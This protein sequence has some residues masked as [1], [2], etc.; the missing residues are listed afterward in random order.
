MTDEAIAGQLRAEQLAGVLRHTRGIMIANICNA[1]I[2]LAAQ[3][4]APDQGLAL[5]WAAMVV[6]LVALLHVRQRTR[7][8]R[9]KPRTVSERAIRRASLY[10]LAL[11]GLWAAVPLLFFNSA[12]HGVQLVIA[13]LCAGM[14]A[15]GAFG[16]G[17][18]PIAA[19]A[20][21]APIFIASAI[22][23]GRSGDAT[24]LLVA[25]LLVVYAL[26]LLRTVFVY[27][28]ENAVRLVAQFDAEQ[29]IRRDPLTQL[30]NRVGFTESVETAFARLASTGE[31]FTLLWLDLDS[32][33]AINDRL[34]HTVGDEI[35]I[36]AADRL[37]ACAG[38]RDA[39]ARLGGD[40]FAVIAAGIGGLDA[41][42]AVARRVVEAF[43]KPFH[44][45]GQEV[46][47]TASIGV[48]IAPGDGS[49]PP[50]LLRSADIALYHAKS[51]RGGSFRF[52][53]VSDHALARERRALQHDLGNALHRGEFRLVYQPILALSDN[54]IVGFEALLRWQ[55]PTRGSV[56][57]T[58]F[59]PVA[60]S[61]GLIRSIGEWVIEE[62]CRT[63]AAWP[64][65]SRISVN[66]SA[67]QFR[68]PAIA[69]QIMAAIAASGLA[70]ERFEIE[71]T[72]TVLLS[73]DETAL[74]ILRTLSAGGIRVALD[75]FGTGYSSLSYLRKLPLHR[76]KIDRSFVQDLKTDLQSAAIVK[77]VIGLATDLGID[78]TA[79]GVETAEQLGFLRAHA[80]GEA[81]G[82]LIG[83]PV[84]AAEAM[85]IL[86]RQ[87]KRPGAGAASA[88]DKPL[89]KA[90]C[91]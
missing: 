14:L 65:P 37:R 24:Y 7:Q 90:H 27:A 48:A 88:A 4:S 19:V 70:P 57:P 28:I 50:H 38:P 42:A 62:A 30:P 66:V 39:L 31:P 72:E 29:R 35:L 91:S 5:I 2:F 64:Q 32:F 6:A 22:A 82:Y 84:D 80:C 76:I 9:P 21:T 51:A 15:G 63:A 46:L 13:C 11:G 77:S 16:L 68:E 67:V 3:W 53:D 71:V 17:G 54:R 10:A 45:D 33:K 36:Q 55:H 85:A 1:L 83:R 43:A 34:G 41:G 44:V 58:A 73:D 81:Q 18:I 74:E 25:A 40:E 78:T 59:I 20:F 75:D 86:R 8:G 49:E 12:G 26:V 69:A 89:P 60:E 56:P 23:I 47:S 61:T 79:E 87:P 52:F